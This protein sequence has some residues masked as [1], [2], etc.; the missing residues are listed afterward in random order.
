MLTSLASCFLGL[1]ASGDGRITATDLA[2]IQQIVDV[3]VA[4]DGSAAVFAVRSVHGDLDDAD[5]ELGY[6]TH[7][8]WIDL[9]DPEAQPVALTSGER[10]AS[11]PAIS[12]DAT[13]LAFVRAGESD[14]DEDGGGTQVW[15]LP[16]DA[17]GEARQLTRLEHGAGAPVWRPDGRALLVS[18]ALPESDIEGTPPWDDE[19]P[20]R[21]RATPDGEASAAGDRESLRR[22][23]DAAADENDPHVI[24]RLAFQ[25]EQ[26]LRGE[27]R[28]THLFLVD[29]AGQATQLTDGFAVHRDARFSP[30]G[31]TI[32]F[33]DRAHDGSHPDRTRRSLLWTISAGGGEARA[34]L[35][36]QRLDAGSPRWAPDGR[37]LWFTASDARDPLFAQRLVGRVELASGTVRWPAV[38][39]DTSASALHV[40]A[41]GLLLFTTSRFGAGPL[42]RVEPRAGERTELYSGAGAITAF[43]VGGGRVVAAATTAGNP[44]EL[45]A[46]EDGGWRRLSD[47]HASWLARVPLSVP[48]ERWLERPDGMRV[49]YWVM[50]PT[51]REPGERYPTVLQMHGGPSV[52]WGPGTFSMWH[53]LQLLCSWGYGVVYANPRGSSGYGY[54]F[55]RANWRD[56]GHGPSADVLAALDAAAEELDWIDEERLFL[57][58]GSYA[59]YLTAWIVAHDQR[60]RAAVAQRGV[61]DLTTFFGEG[62]AWRLVE[63]AFGGKPWEP[64]IRRILARESPFTYVD[65]IRTPLLVMHASQDLRTGVSQSEMLYRALKE[66]ERPVE[67]VR[68]PNAGHDLSRTG[69]PRQR[70]D[71]LARIVEFFERWAENERPAPGTA[72]I[73]PAKPAEASAPRRRRAF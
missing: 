59:G 28:Y 60:F 12:P 42:V 7:L 61:Y 65:R 71:R 15:L 27:P 21:E 1:A 13:T 46:L 36:D 26:A 52:M 72:A 22:W 70:V 38:E 45:Y 51:L 69:D 68:Y 73:E 50:E 55:Q 44:S 48:R 43:D 5:A 30:D 33:V 35:D 34:V 41:D 23:L 6:R 47:L 11:S 64:A 29:L 4:A 40:G 2:R 32:A 10:T 25:D 57:T 24:T 49:Q 16:L 17:P 56:W 18:S 19:R 8:H 62:N 3:D 63:Y 54:D 58:G 20:R 53:E 14:G 39:T 31:A 67:Y 9:T 66:L 37:A